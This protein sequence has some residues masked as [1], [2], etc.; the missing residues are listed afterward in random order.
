MKTGYSLYN[1]FCFK[2]IK[3]AEKVFPMSKKQ[4]ICVDFDGVIANL[5][6]TFEPDVFGDP[7]E[8]TKE[9]LSVLKRKG[10][11]IIVFTT[12]KATAKLKKW[13]KDNEIPYDHIN[14]NPDQPGDAN[15]GKP[16]ADIY[17]DDRAITFDGNWR[18]A[19]ERIARFEPWPSKK[20]DVEKEYD[21]AFEQY[22]K[23]AHKYGAI[24]G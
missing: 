24:C 13:L 5:T 10:F 12:R 22:K 7:V 14:E 18:W 11:T 17:L 2:R 23:M 20:K 16:I 19:L 6:D 21:S 15:A 9:A 1:I 4:V 3:F 8:G